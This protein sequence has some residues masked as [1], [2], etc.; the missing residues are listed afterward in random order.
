MERFLEFATNHFI[1]VSLFIVFLGALFLVDRRRSGQ[2]LSPQ[3]ATMRLNKDEAILV[4]LRDHKEYSEGHI[5]GAKNIPFSRLKERMSELSKDKTIIFVDK[6][7]QHSGMAG[8]M[9]KAEGYELIA[10][11]TGGIA[12]WR[13]GNL[14]LVKK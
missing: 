6:A 11:M 2:S 13:N 8:K 12:E 14:P 10:R 1:L 3:Q 7:G 5:K 9:L 4:D